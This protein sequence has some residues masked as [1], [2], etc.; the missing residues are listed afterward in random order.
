MDKFEK[1]LRMSTVVKQPDYISF[2][3]NLKKFEVTSST[4]EI[5]ELKQVF[6][7]GKPERL[8]ISEKYTPDA[9]GN[10]TIDVKETI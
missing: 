3:G 6:P 4:E 1:K 5:F 9:D 2:S 8:I 10:L 7:G